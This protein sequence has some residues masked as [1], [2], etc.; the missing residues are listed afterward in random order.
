M[1]TE[2]L[3]TSDFIVRSPSP[4][5]T[6]C[7]N[8]PPSRH[9]DQIKCYLSMLIMSAERYRRG[10]FLPATRCILPLLHIDRGV[11]AKTAQDC[12]PFTR[13]T[14][15]RAAPPLP[16]QWCSRRGVRVPRHAPLHIRAAPT[17]SSDLPRPAVAAE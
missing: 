12:C 2:R 7:T 6:R 13:I 4:K 9:A 3:T 1:T 5:L 10:H 14:P 16:L 8:Y 17:Q 11:C 15:R